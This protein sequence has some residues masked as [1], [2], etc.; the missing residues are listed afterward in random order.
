MDE[1]QP[2]IHLN[3]IIIVT[4]KIYIM[5]AVAHGVSRSINFFQYIFFV[6]SLCSFYVCRLCINFQELCARLLGMATLRIRLHYNK[7]VV[8]STLKTIHQLSYY[9]VKLS[10]NSRVNLYHSFLES[11]PN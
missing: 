5:G 7:D 2:P 4:P 8:I 9:H 1:F 10:C 11:Y 3:T 6:A